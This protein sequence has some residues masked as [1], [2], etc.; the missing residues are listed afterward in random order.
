[1]ELSNIDEMIEQL[2]E[3]VLAKFD[4]AFW[5][6]ANELN[7]RAATLGKLLSV[8][9]AFFRE[10]VRPL[11]KGTEQPTQNGVI[12][13]SWKRSYAEDK[14]GELSSIRD[15]LQAEYNDL[16]KQLNGLR[17]QIKDAVRE[18]NLEEERRF[19]TDYGVYRVAAEKYSLEVESV[20]ASAETMRQEAMQELASLRVRTA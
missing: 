10:L 18:Y 2:Q 5:K 20:R 1:M 12:I 7:S 16:Q 13:T 4:L 6:K 19:Q 14:V 15:E 3:P 9:G 8:E 11:P 17:K